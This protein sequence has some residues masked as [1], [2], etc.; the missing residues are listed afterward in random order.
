M[1]FD[2]DTKILTV[3]QNG[4]ISKKAEIQYFKSLTI[5]DIIS[6]CR[7]S[8][9]LD[10]HKKCKI[11]DLRGEELSDDDL[12]Y[13]NSAEPL[14]ISQGE[15][16][17]KNSTMAIFK[18]IKK[19][20][21]GG[22][23]SVYL[24]KNKITKQEVAIKFIDLNRIMSPED[25]NRLFSEISILRGLH[26]KNIVDLLDVFDIE[27]KSCFVME[28]C[29]GGELKNY[30]QEKAPLPEEEVYRI[31][32]QIVEAI[33]YCHNSGI[34]HRD[35]KLENILFAK[36]SKKVVKIVDFGISG[37]FS[38]SNSMNADRSDAGSLHYIAPEILNRSN[39]RA[40]PALDV[41][42]LG[43]IFY[44]MLTK[45]LP[46]TGTRREI[47]NKII[48]CDYPPLPESISKPWHKVI[49]GMLRRTPEARW[50]ILKISDH[51]IKFKDLGRVE[52]SDDSFE[53]KMKITAARSNGFIKIRNER[54]RTPDTRNS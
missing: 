53:I 36:P 52:V 35:L 28:Y 7:D 43:C 1:D 8:F 20:G 40:N 29:S 47:I 45:S 32:L 38:L 3:F 31:S 50:N 16:F 12:E 13:V 24:Y 17:M 44:A 42:S 34:V 10:C 26:H 39:N 9:S 2:S 6:N 21:Q 22:F 4:N 33:R 37:N 19:L 41:W 49:K 25:V 30:I 54:R 51:L 18:E 27:S 46:F 15:K 23:G 48:E 5:T 14:F 11:L